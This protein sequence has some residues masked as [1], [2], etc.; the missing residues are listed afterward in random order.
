MPKVSVLMPLFNGKSFIEESIR[1]VQAQTFT[2]WE[3]IIV[4][5][6]GSDDGCADIV[7]S[8]AEKDQRIK[9]LQMET[10]L[11]L[12]A[13][14]NEGLKVASG[15]YVARVD[16]D[17]PSYPTRF[18]K[19]V[20]FM[21]AHPDVSLCGVWQ[22]S[23]SPKSSSVQRVPTE[24]EELKASMLFG[25]EISHCG[26]MLRKKDFDEH[27][28]RYDPS[29]LSEDYELWTR[30]LFDG[31]KIANL[32]EV[33]VD[34]RWGFENISIAKGE[35]LRAETGQLSMRMVQ[36]TGAD[37]SGYS[38]MLFRGWRSKPTEYARANTT[39]FLQQGYSLL[40]DIWQA[41]Y[42]SGFF[43]QDA[44]KKVLLKRWNWICECCGIPFD[45]ERF[46]RPVP[47]CSD[48][49]KISVVLPSFCSAKVISQSIDSI[50]AQIY[51]DWELLVV[52]DFG[53][54][55]G[56]AEI[57]KM[58]AFADPR[59]RLVQTET[60]LGLAESLN[61]GIRIARG[62]YIAR[63]DAD[64]TSHPKRFEKQVA[65]MDAHPEVGICGT[66]Q[67]HYGKS[68]DSIHKAEP[69]LK[70]MKA[71]LLFWCD[72]CHSTLMLRRDMFLEHSLFYDPDYLAEDFELWSR[73]MEYMEIANIPVV[74][75]EYN[76][77][78]GITHD[79]QKAIKDESGRIT[80]RN[81]S[82]YLNVYIPD[83]KT[84]LLDGWDNSA[85]KGTSRDD[86]L[87]Q[88]KALFI[89]IWQ[90]NQREKYFDDAALL[91]VLAKKWYWAKDNADW[92]TGTYRVNMIDD[93][94]KERKVKL[95]VNKYQSFKEHNP[96]ASQRAKKITKKALSPFAKVARRLTLAS[97]R[98]VIEEID[99]SIERWTWN[100]YQRT[101]SKLASVS[102]NGGQ[103]SPYIP[104]YPGQ[105]IRVIFLMQV[106]SF[107]PAQE[108]VYKALACDPRFDVR[109]ICYDEP[110][111]KSIKTNTTRQYLQENG[112]DFVPWEDFDIDDFNPHIA[113]L[114]TAYD[115]NRRAVYKSENLKDRGCR[116]IYIPYGIEIAD[117]RHA[118]H[119][120][121]ERPIISNA[122]KVFTFSDEMRNEYLAHIRSRIDIVATGLPR[123]DALYHKETFLPNPEII[124]RANGRKIVLWKVHF[125]KVITQYGQS[126]VVTPE[127]QEY[128]DFANKLDDYN[129]LFFIF[130]PHP[131]FR[132]FN[133]D[134]VVKA[135]T[136]QLMSILE[137]KDNVFIDDADDYRPSLLNS[138]AIIVDRSA[139][140]IEAAAADVPI[141]YMA[142]ANYYEPMTE[143]VRP[144][145]ESYE[146]GTTCK[147][148][149]AFIDR[150]RNGIDQN[151]IGRNAAFAQC[152]PHFDGQ[153][154]ARITENIVRSLEKENDTL[155]NRVENL[156]QQIKELK[157]S[158]S[159][160]K[161]PEEAMGRIDKSVERWTWDRYQRSKYDVM[162]QTWNLMYEMDRDRMK[163]FISTSPTYD[164]AFYWD[165][166]Y[167]S[168]NSAQR[169][170]YKL[171]QVLPHRSVVDFGCGTGTWLWV[172]QA[173]GTEEVLGIDGDYIPRD[174]LMI[175][176]EN[177]SPADLENGYR[178]EKKY[179]LAMSLEVA[180]HLSENAADRFVDTLCNAADI[181]LFSAA[182]PGQG[183]D[184]H[185]NEQPIE[186]WVTKFK[187][188][189]YQWIDVRAL[190]KGDGNIKPWYRHNL[191]L[192]VK[193]EQYENM[194]LSSIEQTEAGN[195]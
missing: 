7:R 75:G 68:I 112:Y 89:D 86:N 143:A 27:G 125:P 64:D 17:D 1:S 168:V 48:A 90:A 155:E 18:E 190:F 29:F 142:N 28:W 149:V 34:H 189:G 100:R 50:L 33:L 192:F 52:N 169:I 166:R 79:K 14:L 131:R 99:K 177:F 23:V 58:Y 110:I 144:L 25:C 121:F 44:L 124:E 65:Y 19:Q 105:R 194:D 97:S 174:M 24:E 127:I 134:P 165:N 76:H 108:S 62:E 41:N 43:D 102:R 72:L 140:M 103:V 107:W 39:Q 87:Q 37:P 115:S 88:L 132:E 69:D 13:S 151:K 15:E 104:Y 91:Q 49:P 153:C 70:P 61:H 12:A 161:I 20:A 117:T 120:H 21:D 156:E 40:M 56:T 8:F 133:D 38:P 157:N 32:P 6:F 5:D 2:D 51:T 119:D 184:R 114:Q 4:N 57:V 36:H 92:K 95:L 3:F 55:D 96:S 77:D 170:L 9:L 35:K 101:E 171:F 116:V 154:S 84:F 118:R 129:D 106:A 152:I 147:D 160:R 93:V 172:A 182:H 150:F 186:Y 85:F 128:I 11:G 137:N 109:L 73:A 81:L 30:L 45:A 135:Q 78:S 71:K 148:I 54:E 74:L 181:V 66:W 31:A 179:D 185:I 162:D 63:L 141:L 83:Q 16:V 53:S 123:F 191:A 113:F 187:E 159:D 193:N 82:H 111:D 59:I 10:R 145:V 175:P 173:F 46:T 146:Q 67:H 94:F 47:V 183:G 138:D 26:A 42:T 122:W 188:K 178:V 180:E 130:M 126:I 80:A 98:T 139:V 195:L 158:M 60:R 22:N 163:R 136:K 176:A 164:T 167:G